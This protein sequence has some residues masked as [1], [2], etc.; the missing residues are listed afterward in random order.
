M[1]VAIVHDWLTVFA[2]AEKALENILEIFPEADL[3]TTVDF[4]NEEDRS[5]LEGHKIITSFIQNLPFARKK[6]RAYLPLMPF[7]IEQ[8]DL[9]NY[10]VVISSSHAVAKGVITSPYQTHISYIY[11]PMRYAWDLQY[12]YLQESGLNNR[13]KGWLARYVLHK[14]RIWDVVTSNRVD[15]MIAISNFIAS[16]IEKIYRRNVPVIYPPVDT[17]S[18]KICNEKD[19]FYVTVSRMVPYKKIDLI[20][21]AFNMMPDKKLIVIG[22]GPDFKKIAQKAASNVKLMGFQPLEVVK[23]YLQRAK[24]FVFAAIEDFGI[25]PVEAQACGTPV[26]A[27]GKGGVL[28]TVIDEKTGIFF[29]EQSI[30]SIMEAVKKFEI[31]QIGSPEE[32]RTNA[33]RFSAENF[34]I[35][36]TEFVNNK[37]SKG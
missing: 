28:E 27:F 34:K 20:V 3:Y 13:L 2:G 23:E 1:K 5:F 17:D 35:K 22:D 11:S 16:R 30:R 25:A 7:A 37:I 32:I 15:Y 26:I 8:F 29:Y 6:Y 9:T 18:F 4:L 31:I 24:A 36:F 12:Q 14:M 19:D 33:L 21:E 10:D